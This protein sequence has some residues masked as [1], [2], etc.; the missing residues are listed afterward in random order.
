MNLVRIKYA[1]KIVLSIMLSKWIN[2]ENLMDA[3]ITH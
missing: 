1:V 3:E 2:D